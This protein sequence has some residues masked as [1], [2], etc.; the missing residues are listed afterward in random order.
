MFDRMPEK[1]ED[2]QVNCI[3]ATNNEDTNLDIIILSDEEMNE[4]MLEILR[5]VLEE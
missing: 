1:F 5:L 4:L 2:F 3:D